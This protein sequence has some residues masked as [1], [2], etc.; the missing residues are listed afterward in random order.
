MVEETENPDIEAEVAALFCSDRL[1]GGTDEFVSQVG[2][3]E[4]FAEEP[5]PLTRSEPAEPRNVELSGGLREAISERIGVWLQ[6]AELD[7]KRGELLRQEG[8]AAEWRGELDRQR[9]EFS[10]PPNAEKLVALRERQAKKNAAGI[11]AGGE[12]VLALGERQWRLFEDLWR[13]DPKV[14]R[15]GAETCI[16]EPLYA[17]FSQIGLRAGQELLGRTAYL[18]ALGE[19]IARQGAERQGIRRRIEA[20]VAEQKKNTGILGRLTSAESQPPELQELLE[21]ERRRLAYV[22]AIQREN[23]GLEKE[24]TASFWNVY[25]AV[26]MK[27]AAGETPAPFAPFVRAFLRYGLLGSGEAFI[28]NAIAREILGDCQRAVENWDY[29]QGATHVLYADEYIWFCARGYTTPAIDQDLELNGKNTPPWRADKAWRRIINCNVCEM[30]LRELLGKLQAEAVALRKRQEAAEQRKAMLDRRNPDHKA[31]YVQAAELAQTCRVEAARK[32]RLCERLTGEWIP[33]QQAQRED[34]QSR[35]AEA[36]VPYVPG[37][38]GKREAQEVRR[39]TRLCA[40]LQEQFPPLALRDNFQPAKGQVN[41]RAELLAELAE[42]EKADAVIFKEPLFPTEKK[43]QR[44]Y[45]RFSPVLLIAPGCG[46]L[47]YSWNPRSGVELGRLVVPAYCPRPGLR[48]KILHYLLADFRWETSKASAGVDLLTSDTVVAGYCTVRWD[49]R[50]RAKETREKAGIYTEESDRLNFRRHYSL[51][52]SSA[53]DGGKKLFF[54]C[55]EAYEV[56]LKYL[57]LPPGVDR[58]RK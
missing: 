45:L 26:A 20:F 36:G 28:D 51:Y 23:V 16:K 24:L 19:L 49:Y 32:E 40:K 57:G 55:L 2:D 42:L 13:L 38:L 15:A 18:L 56:M 53:N 41:S 47:G 48:E 31:V 17:V 39:V 43:S 30:A 54:K 14:T 33:K 34:A 22:A 21:K 9:Q 46:F 10:R 12:V 25:E 52:V 35:L 6:L 11:P 7:E 5:I 37:E 50:K 27:F 58:L 4:E 8:L 44:V 3:F 29:A 1:A